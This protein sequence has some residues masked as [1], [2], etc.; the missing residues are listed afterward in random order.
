M[1]DCCEEDSTKKT[2]KSGIESAL[3]LILIGIL[4]L[5]V[6]VFGAWLVSQSGPVS[7]ASSENASAFAPET[8][9]DWGDIDIGGGSA[10]HEFTIENRGTDPLNITNVRTSCSCTTA[11]VMVGDSWSPYFGMHSTSSWVGTINP[12]ESATLKVTFD[13]AFHVPDALGPVE[14]F[15]AVETN[16]AENPSLEFALTGDVVKK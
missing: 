6:L 4:T 15:I 14:R 12:G 5:T 13:P 3:P 1:S 16:D 7:L 2:E 9:F 8:S 11:Q 10:T